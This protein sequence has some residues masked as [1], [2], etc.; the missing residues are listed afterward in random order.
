VNTPA[1]T[2]GYDAHIHPHVMGSVATIIA[3]KRTGVVLI[4]FITIF[5]FHKIFFVH[6]L[7]VRV[8]IDGSRRDSVRAEKNN[9][10]P[11]RRYC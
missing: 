2:A 7:S 10:R 4:Y 8:I 11:Y 5:F 6:C 3:V 1:A 9:S